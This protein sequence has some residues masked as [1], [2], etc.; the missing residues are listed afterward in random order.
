MFCFFFK[1]LFCLFLYLFLVWLV[2]LVFDD[3]T[4]ASCQSSGMVPGK[5][6]HS[7]PRFQGFCRSEK[8]LS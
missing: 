4:G 2:W 1:V 6:L 3:W 7:Q 5:T 8:A